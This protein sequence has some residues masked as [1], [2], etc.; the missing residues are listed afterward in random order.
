MVQLGNEHRGYTVQ[1]RATFLMYGGENYQWVEAFHHYF[2]TA[3][4]QTVHG[5]KYYTEAVEE[6]DTNA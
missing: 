6:G 5:G 4:C 2:R 3:M 1:S